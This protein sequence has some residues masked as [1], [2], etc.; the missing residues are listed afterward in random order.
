MIKTFPRFDLIR[1]AVA[2]MTRRERWQSVGI[3]ALMLADGLLESSVVALVVPLVY[4]IVDPSRFAGSEI[5]TKLT[6]FLGQ[7]VE[8]LFP[9]IAVLLIILL[10]ASTAVT[11]LATHFNEKHSALCRDRLAAEVLRQIASAPYTWLLG[12]SAPI[13]ARHVHEDVRAWRK[14]FIQALLMIVQAAI[15]IAA[16]AA[17]AVAIAPL[18]GFAALGVVAV[19]CA[20]VVAVFRRKIRTISQVSKVA[21]DAMMRSLMQILAGIR[22]IKVTGHAQYFIDIFDRHHSA[23]T[24]SGVAARMFGGAPAITITLLGQVGFVATAM[25]LWWRGG[26]GAEIIAQLALIGVVVSRVVPAANSLAAQVSQL[27]RSA[28][29]V[30]S[31][32]RFRQK[33]DAITQRSERAEGTFRPLPSSWKTLSLEG[34]SFRYPGADH[35]SLDDV[36]M[37]LERGRFYGFVGRS[38]AGKTTLVN[39][40][41]GLMEPTE[42]QV[43]V[44]SV[45]LHEISLVE[46]HKKFG[47]VPQDAFILDGSLRE[48]VAFGEPIDDARVMSALDRA[49]L[50]PV[51]QALGSGLDTQLGER[52]RRFSGGQAQRVAIARALYKGCDVMLL[53]EAT[54]ALDS[55]TEAEIYESI[56]PLR[57]EVLTLMIAHRVSSLRRCD[58]IFVLDAGRIVDAGGYAELN[59]RSDIFRSL[60]AT[61]SQPARI[62]DQV[63]AK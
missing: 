44:D 49:Q 21:G 29:F 3:V 16:P 18:A 8:T 38:G 24:N 25:V 37:S 14:E 60:A 39:L 32:V 11:L 51:V 12:Q 63:G 52:G 34:V 7:P 56:E 26:T 40:L 47:Y 62:P 54:S 45:P 58:R 6:S 48:N 50:G 20:L 1:R 13:L 53:D 22:E 27:Y 23:F 33:L 19:L 42:G 4:V 46:W 10:M 30:E 31:L 15:K 2:L 59:E 35:A 43:M 36:Q 41:L 57:G 5:G 9:W 61:E 55:I 17:V 28:P